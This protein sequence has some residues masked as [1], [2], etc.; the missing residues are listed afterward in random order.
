MHSSAPPSQIEPS[1]NQ[2]R[3][4]AT[5]LYQDKIFSNSVIGVSPSE[6]NHSLNRFQ[7]AVAHRPKRKTSGTPFR[8]RRLDPPIATRNPEAQKYFDQG[9]ALFYGFKR[10]ESLR[11]FRKPAQLDPQA[12]MADWGIA[13][14]LPVS[15]SKNPARH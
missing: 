3:L 15:T 12:P 14:A 7:C 5:D 8:P 2:K 9:L 10:Y 4:Q 1:P 6:E 11:S 13:M